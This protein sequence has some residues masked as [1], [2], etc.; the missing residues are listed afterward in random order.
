[1]RIVQA[2]FIIGVISASLT[3]P[4]RAEVSVP[5]PACG[6]QAPVD[7]V[8]ARL[9]PMGEAQGREAL[10]LQR[11]AP[12]SSSV[13]PPADVAARSTTETMTVVVDGMIMELPFWVVEGQ[14]RNGTF[15]VIGRWT[16]QFGT[17]VPRW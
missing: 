6:W 1:M 15:I 2:F 11:L 3:A 5:P 8:G 14:I 10:L 4:A 17:L 9:L 13:P 12:P 16:I 7:L